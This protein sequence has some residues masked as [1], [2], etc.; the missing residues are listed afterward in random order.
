MVEV[1][2]NGYPIVPAGGGLRA[3]E[4]GWDVMGDS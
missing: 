3:G 4:G 2:L 1:W